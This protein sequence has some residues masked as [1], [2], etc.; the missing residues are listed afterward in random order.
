MRHAEASSMDFLKV[1]HREH[2]CGIS[3]HISMAQV[4]YT[5]LLRDSGLI[6]SCLLISFFVFIGSVSGLKTRQ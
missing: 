6:P 1:Y 2:F 5:L 3:S 4:V